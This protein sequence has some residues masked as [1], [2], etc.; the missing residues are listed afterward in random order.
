MGAKK[1]SGRD[2]AHWSDEGKGEDV[3]RHEDGG[4]DYG[5]G[6]DGTIPTHDEAKG[7][8]GAGAGARKGDGRDAERWSDER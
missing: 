3:A 1:G 5:R 8:G 6:D 7:N 2:D 4:Q